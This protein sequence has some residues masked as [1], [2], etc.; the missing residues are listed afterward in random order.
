MTEKGL[1]LI[2]H[3][4]RLFFLG[5]RLM[6]RILALIYPHFSDKPVVI[7]M[8]KSL[9]SFKEHIGE[10]IIRHKIH[11]NYVALIGSC[12]NNKRYNSG[13]GIHGNIIIVKEKDD[14][15]LSLNANDIS[16]LTSKSSLIKDKIRNIGERRKIS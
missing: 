6:Q 3:V 5:R 16:Y 2:D 14:I 10:E 7:N 15:L 9:K 13:I 1:E 12:K 11:K 4:F 8:P